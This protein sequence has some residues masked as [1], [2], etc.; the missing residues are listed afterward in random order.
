ME[1]KTLMIR[2]RGL[3]NYLRR[4]LETNRQLQEGNH[5]LGLEIKMGKILRLNLHQKAE[6]TALTVGLMEALVCS[7]NLCY[8]C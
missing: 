1:W 3:K 6:M 5:R 8:T 2:W 4:N 7:E